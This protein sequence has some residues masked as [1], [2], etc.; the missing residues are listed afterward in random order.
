MK[1]QNR[2]ATESGTCSSWC[3]ERLSQLTVHENDE[4]EEDKIQSVHM[5]NSMGRLIKRLP[6]SLLR[7]HTYHLYNWHGP[8]LP[9][10]QGGVTDT[11][12]GPSGMND[13]PCMLGMLCTLCVL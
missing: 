2:P 6:K 12:V 10:C 3:M 13:I 9:L 4:Y 1:F 11:Q 7:H 8:C 5:L